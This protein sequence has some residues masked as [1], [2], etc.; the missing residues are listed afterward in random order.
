[1]C[2]AYFLQTVINH[3]ETAY[4][5]INLAISTALTHRK[6]VF[7]A[8]ASNLAA[9]QHPSLSREPFEFQ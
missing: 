5:Q 8:I 4:S 2:A 9:A 3:I 7:I 1:M 6:P